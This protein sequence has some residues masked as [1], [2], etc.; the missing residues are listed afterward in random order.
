MVFACGVILIGGHFFLLVGL[1]HSMAWISPGLGLPIFMLLSVLSGLFIL[2]IQSMLE[3]FFIRQH[4]K[5]NPNSGW[6]VVALGVDK[7]KNAAPKPARE[8]RP[9]LLA[10][11]AW[12]WGADVRELL[13][14]SWRA[15]DMSVR[16]RA[17][18]LAGTAGQRLQHL[19]VNALKPLLM[20]VSRP[21]R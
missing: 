19:V 20:R 21:V 5:R 1:A 15:D 2:R 9:G 7:K 10:Q 4:L 3:I 17:V 16:D 13:P 8:A 11:A 6:N 18:L 12:L 14:E